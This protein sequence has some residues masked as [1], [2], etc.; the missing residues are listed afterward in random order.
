MTRPVVIVGAGIAGLWT[1]LKLAPKP[2][3]VLTGA[4]LGTSAATAWAQGGIAAALGDGDSADLHAGDTIAAGAGLTCPEAATALAQGIPEQIASLQAMGVPFDIDDSGRIALGLEAAHS[5]PRIAHI[6]GDQA[7]QAIL[8]V[9]I[10]AARKA[11]HID[12]RKGWQ[13]TGLIPSYEG[14]CAGVIVRDPAGERDD[15]QAAHTVLATGGYGGLFA[16]TTSPQGATGSA[17]AM[18]MAIGAGFRNPE[19]VQFHPTAIQIGGDPLPLATEAL[20]GT[21]ARIVDADGKS[22]TDGQDL[23]PRDV[24]ARAVYHANRSGRQSYLDARTAVGEAF[25]EAFPGVF[26]ACQTAGIDPR[27]ELIPICPAAHYTMG[28]IATDLDGHTGVTG[29]WAVGECA[30]N[31]LHG[32]NRLASNSLAEG[33][34]IGY[35]LAEALTSQTVRPSQPPRGQQ[36]TSLPRLVLPGLRRAMSD[37]AGVERDATGLRDLLNRIDRLEARY[38]RTHETIL[39]R[40]IAVAA[41]TRTESRGAH[42]RLDFPHPAAQAEDT[43]IAPMN[44]TARAAE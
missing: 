21:G 13:A 7:G 31:G 9:L 35:R 16:D 1:A 26:N 22:I 44:P 32:A 36:V 39:S 17:I 23:A 24:V 43:L 5:H 2:V 12:I 19:F 14:G 40:T 27:T 3:I 10:R 34:V 38:G 29:L 33:L 15:L 28:G 11:D 30:N 18:A 6:K 8:G 37:L 25:P 20:R 42:F 41:L 4:A